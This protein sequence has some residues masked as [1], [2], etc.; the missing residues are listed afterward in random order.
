MIREYNK[1]V[2]DR[3]PA[4]IESKGAN[5]TYHVLSDSEYKE[6][7]MNKLAEEFEEL[8]QADT[9]EEV[10][11]ELADLL[12][13]CYALADNIGR[14]KVFDRFTNKNIERGLFK[15]RYFLES[16]ENPT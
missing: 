9:E 4:I 2:R 5:V 7:L 10:I 12:S 15:K 13:V 6:A 3:I 16:V 14:D 11:E 1:L 8:L